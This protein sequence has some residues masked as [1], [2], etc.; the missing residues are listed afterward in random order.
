MLAI[1]AERINTPLKKLESHTNIKI[2]VTLLKKKHRWN[3]IK[4]IS[5]INSLALSAAAALSLHLCLILCNPIASS[6]PGSSVHGDS[7]DRNP[8]VG[9]HALL[10]ALPGGKEESSHP[11]GIFPSQGSNPGLLHCRWILHHL[12]PLVK[13]CYLGNYKLYTDSLCLCVHMYTNIKL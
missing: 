5:F 11:R 4:N 7:P 2:N 6:P 12:E 3:F 10:R 1:L 13:Q 9:C 8:G